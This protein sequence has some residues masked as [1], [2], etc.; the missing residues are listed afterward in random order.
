M[1]V[2]IVLGLMNPA[3]MIAI[4]VVIAAEKLM[5]KPELIA[6]ISGAA[7]VITGLLLLARIFF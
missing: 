2:L 5:P 7:A 6:R 4:A 1:T 3:V